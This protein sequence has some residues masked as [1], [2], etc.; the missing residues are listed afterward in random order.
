MKSYE[1]PCVVSSDGLSEG[2]YMGS[3]ENASDCWTINPYS[4]QDWNGDH[5]VFEI[6]CAHTTAV[7]HIST[8]A[9]VTLTFS[10][11]LTDAYTESNFTCSFSGNTATVVRTLH[12]NAYNSGDHVTF[13]VWAKASDEATT[14]ALAVTGATISCTKTANVQ[15]E[16][17]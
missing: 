1:K 5:H 2:V 12:A 4:V 13:K 6:A 9:T 11:T 10:N 8:A 17:D 3:G 16:I 7:K 14:K 15:G